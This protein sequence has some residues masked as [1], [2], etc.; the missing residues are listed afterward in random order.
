MP[1]VDPAGI[2]S[3]GPACA[4]SKRCCPFRMGPQ[5]GCVRAWCR[6]STALAE[7]MVRAASFQISGQTEAAL[8]EL[9]RA[10]RSGHRSPK[11]ACAIGHLQ[12]ELRQIEAA[13]QTYEDAARQ[14]DSDATAV[15]NLAV[16]QERLGAFE[17]AAAAFAKA[18]EMDPRRTGALL[19]LGICQLHLHHPQA[20]LEAFERCLERQPFREAALRGA[21][22]ALL[23]LNRLDE[24]L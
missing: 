20:A 12:F 23:L 17:Q 18:A 9:T 8:D 3:R 22:F 24:A 7:S 13:A 11:L 16:C 15:Y 1:A 19:G 21:A 14:D 6:M 10:R 2:S 4:P 5:S